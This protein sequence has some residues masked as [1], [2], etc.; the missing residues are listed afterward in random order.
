MHVFFCI[1]QTICNFLRGSLS[2]EVKHNQRLAKYQ[3]NRDT[4]GSQ[5]CTDDQF[6]TKCV[7]H[8]VMISAAEKLCAKNSGTGNRAENRQIKYKNQ[9]VGNRNAGHLL[10]SDPSDHD[11][12]QHTHKLG[13]AVLYHNG[14]RYR[15]RKLI[16]RTI[17]EIFFS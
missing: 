16:K 17:P 7:A 4:A 1:A 14:N 2:F 15:Q 5:Q 8:T 13:N 6:E 3:E 12:I 9:R 11:I 10:R